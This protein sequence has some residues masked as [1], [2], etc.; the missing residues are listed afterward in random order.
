MTNYNSEKL[1]LIKDLTKVPEI[2]NYIKL[3]RSGL[4]RCC[5]E[6][7]L[8]INHIEKCFSNEELYID[9]EQLEKYMDL[10]K[11]FPFKLFDWEV[12]CFTLHNCVR[13]KDGLLRWQT[14]FALLG[15]GAGKN[16][17]LGFEDFALL[18]PVNGI[19]EYHIDIFAMSEEQAET[20][21]KDI[22]NILEE[23]KTKLS[24]HFKWNKEVITNLKTK[25]ELKFRTSNFKSKDG[26]R[27]GKVDF[28]EYHAYEN[29]KLV[30]VANTGLGK[31]PDPRKTIVTTDGHVRE[32]P[33]DTIKDRAKAVLNGEE[34]D[35]GTLFFICKLGNEDE[36][37]DK[38]NWY[39]ANPSL[40]YLP[41]LL[42]QL[43]SEYVD[44]LSDPIGNISFCVKRM[45]L[46]KGSMDVIVTEW[47][48]IIATNEPIIDLIGQD[49]I[50]G[51]D[52]AKTTDFVAAGLLFKRDNK[53]YWI[54]HTWVCRKSKDL[55]RIKAPLEEW[56]QKGL[57]TFVDGPEIPPEIPA[58]WL[59]EQGQFY[60]IKTLCLDN[61]R[62]TLLRKA[63]KDVG[64]DTDKKGRNNIKLI[65]PSDE[66]KIS[67]V[68]TSGFNNNSFVWGDNPLMRWY[69]NNT[70]VIV[71]G[72]NITYG[73][74]EEK[75]RKTD[76]FKAFVAAMT[77]HEL[78]DN[79]VVYVD[80]D[81]GV[82]SY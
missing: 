42:S 35:N 69:C 5:E 67:P 65:R 26:G 25:S 41:T 34:P 61:Y 72:S 82:Y 47:D 7:F 57:L 37:H 22:Y 45:N 78:L 8:L 43:E 17:Y 28:D 24:K 9:L 81:L 62:F 44:Y 49:C 56:E 58:K 2:Y 54:T 36:I 51:I 19:K 18:T 21:F 14:L 39:K 79:A 75:S 59:S 68:I 80:I 77:E 15:R 30:D 66:M 1:T 73:K 50:A 11:Y 12:F 64:F 76:G 55:H 32:G 20:T 31:K 63:L 16:G 40:Q 53:F 48:N 27:P 71:S 10:Q 23:N 46:P 60:N 13:K 74:I 4:Y 29:M 70:C 6:Q 33:L 38:L 52:Y 3:V